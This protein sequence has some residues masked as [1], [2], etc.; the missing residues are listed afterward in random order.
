MNPEYIL[1]AA[2]IGSGALWFLFRKTE[3]SKVFKMLFLSITVVVA[4][5]L[6]VTLIFSAEDIIRFLQQ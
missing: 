4:A 6:I 1:F 2:W 5:L 3:K